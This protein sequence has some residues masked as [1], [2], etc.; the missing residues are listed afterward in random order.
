MK[1]ESMAIVESIE[2]SCIV[3]A[4]SIAILGSAQR[5]TFGVARVRLHVMIEDRLLNNR[6][7][8]VKLCFPTRRTKVKPHFRRKPSGVV[9]SPLGMGKLDGLQD[10]RA[11]RGKLTVMLLAGI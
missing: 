7:S 4:I 5:Q 2:A 10:V 11:L 3:E 6:S 8:Q 9:L 1:D